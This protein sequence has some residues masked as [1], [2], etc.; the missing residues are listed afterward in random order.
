LV[1][2]NN[3]RRIMPPFQLTKFWIY[4]IFFWAKNKISD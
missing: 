3:I 1:P 4:N 2:Y